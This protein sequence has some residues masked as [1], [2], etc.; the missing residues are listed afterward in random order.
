[1]TDYEK[2]LA[3]KVKTRTDG[4]FIADTLNANLFPF[5]EFIVKRALKAGKYAI[6]AD[7]GLGKTLMQLSW[8]EAVAKHTCGRVLIL[9]PLAVRGQT[10]AEGERFKIDMSGIDV[11]NYEQIDNI[12]CDGY[13]GIVLDES[14]ILKNYEGATKSII[15][16]RFKNTAYKLACTL[17]S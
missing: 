5:Q 17:E 14:S 16:D 13:A 8:A 11:Q 4:G 2:F 15:I 1:M 6:F 9:A 7:C 10:I 12:D 3:T